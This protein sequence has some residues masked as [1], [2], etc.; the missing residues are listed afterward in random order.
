MPTPSSNAPDPQSPRS[1]PFSLCPEPEEQ[2]TLQAASQPQPQQMAPSPGSSWHPS[3]QRVDTVM[4]ND[5]ATSRSGT[6]SPG[7]QLESGD[8]VNMEQEHDG[9]AITRDDSDEGHKR[10]DADDEML[11]MG[12]ESARGEIGGAIG[13]SRRGARPASGEAPGRGQQRSERPSPGVGEVHEVDVW[14]PVGKGPR[15]VEDSGLV[16]LGLEYS[17]MR[18]VPSPPS[19]YLRPGSRFVGTQQS[20]RQRYDVEVEIKHVDMRESFM[21]GYLKIQGWLCP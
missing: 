12:E 7:S 3:A 15:W 6:M 20:K 19:F 1:F 13:G 9:M 10:S 18:V 17:H 2:Q 21:C 4:N 14:G 5:D 8:D 16:G 11:T